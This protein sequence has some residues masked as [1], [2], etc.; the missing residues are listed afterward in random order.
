MDKKKNF[1]FGIGA[2]LIVQLIISNLA[3]SQDESYV[4][5]V[6][7]FDHGKM[8]NLLGGK[9]QGDEEVPG[10]CVPTFTKRYNETYGRNGCS[11]K[12]DF[13]VTV[14]D[15]FSYYWSRLSSE[16]T[17]LINGK[18]VDVIALKDLSE[19]DYLSF[20]LM[21]PK[22]GVDFTIELHQDA[23]GD[24]VYIIGKDI[25]A[26]VG[27]LR[28]YNKDMVGKWQK[29]VIPTSHFKGITSWQK[30]LELVFV[31]RNGHGIQKGTVYID[32]ILFGKGY[33]E[34]LKVDPA[35]I[36]VAPNRSTFKSDEEN[37]RDGFV[38]KTIN[39]LSVEAVART[40]EPRI[41][42]VKFEFSDDLGE[43]WRMIAKDY[44][45]TD[46][47]YKAVWTTIGLNETKKYWTRAAVGTIS[48]I[49]SP[50]EPA[51]ADC[52]IRR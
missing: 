25:T 15:S 35:T 41:E 20:W 46:Q 12:L 52:A 14:R 6:D 45:L 36:I 30:I 43:T 38:F 39:N 18:K 19:Y 32:D 22:G 37:I 28:Y 8:F 24:G 9:T 50:M 49:A 44:N 4:L 48:G 42:Y 33:S 29:I 10:G 7:D 2:L 47:F 1:V 11:L 27:I 40:S 3:L 26:S 5:L 21:D 23:D 17:N 13:D 51:V 16:Y 34:S 31:F